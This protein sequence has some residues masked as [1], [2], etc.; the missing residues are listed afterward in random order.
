MTDRNNRNARNARAL[1]STRG[2]PATPPQTNAPES[3][4]SQVSE[5]GGASQVLASV[6]GTGEGASAGGG[7]A[8]ATGGAG[9][10][11]NA[12]TGAVGAGAGEATNAGVVSGNGD[13]PSAPAQVS[14]GALG[15]VTH[16]PRYVTHRGTWTRNAA[17]TLR[18]EARESGTFL[19]RGKVD[20]D[21]HADTPTHNAEGIL[22]KPDAAQ[23]VGDRVGV[24]VVGVAPDVLALIFRAQGVKVDTGAPESVTPGA[25]ERAHLSDLRAF[26]PTLKGAHG[27]LVMD[28]AKNL[29]GS[30]TDPKVRTD[31]LSILDKGAKGD[32]SGRIAQVVTHA[33]AAWGTNAPSTPPATPDAS[34][35]EGAPEG[36]PAQV[37]ASQGVASVA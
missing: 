26:I 8:G 12:N 37:D 30:L 33:R 16:A 3:A 35:V 4:P 17:G 11:S 34:K 1:S 22:I 19:S 15:T 14:Q 7:D 18:V 32:K 27:A 23:V 5:T 24:L 20:A 9:E 2:A 28:A 21:T 6:G 13:T 31:A 36:A 10:G 29:V 25:D